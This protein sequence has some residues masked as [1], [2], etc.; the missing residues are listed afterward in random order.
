M[1]QLEVKR[2]VPKYGLFIS[3]VRFVSMFNVRMFKHKHSSTLFQ[4]H[5]DLTHQPP[6]L[7]SSG[8]LGRP[9][10]C[11]EHFQPY[12]EQLTIT[13]SPEGLRKIV[14][15]A[16][17][18]V[19]EGVPAAWL[20]SCSAPCRMTLRYQGFLVMPQTQ[21]SSFEIPTSI[22]TLRRCGNISQSISKKI[23]AFFLFPCKVK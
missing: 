23:T 18:A 7:L 20:F 22:F 2:N 12:L 17:S 13:P 9:R 4:S 3:R 1:C 11:I 8:T 5:A 10:R 21:H 14:S 6:Y 15:A 16:S 19:D